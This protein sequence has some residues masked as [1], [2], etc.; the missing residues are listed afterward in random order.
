MMF[1]TGV[2]LQTVAVV[3]PDDY[4]TN[5]SWSPCSRS[6]VLSLLNR[7][8]K[9]RHPDCESTI[10]NLFGQIQQRNLS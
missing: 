10:A 8:R 4:L 7:L 2:C 9:D 3:K 5:C 6:G 1:R